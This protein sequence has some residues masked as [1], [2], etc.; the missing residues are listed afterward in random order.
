MSNLLRIAIGLCCAMALTVSAAEGK[1]KGSPLTDE[2]KAVRKELTEKYDANKDKKLDK[3]EMSK[4][5][6][7]DKE[8]WKKAFPGGPKKKDK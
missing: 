6:A 2:Q 7:E 3:E 5:S 8:K 1:K 4:M